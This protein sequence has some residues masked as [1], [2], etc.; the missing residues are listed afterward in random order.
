MLPNEEQHLIDLATQRLAA[1]HP[2]KSFAEIGDAVTRARVHFDGRPIRDFVPLLI[3]R[4]AD[5][6]LSIGPPVTR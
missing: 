5:R 1:K 3:E 4:H 6:E 2:E